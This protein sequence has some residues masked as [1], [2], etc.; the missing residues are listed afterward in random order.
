MRTPSVAT[1]PTG[2]SQDELDRV[3][4]MAGKDSYVYQRLPSS[5]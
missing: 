3:E 4:R 5:A 1:P 2:V